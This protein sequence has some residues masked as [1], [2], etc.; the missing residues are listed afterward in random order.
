MEDKRKV[1]KSLCLTWSGSS[2]WSSKE[3]AEPWM[4]KNIHSDHLGRD[5]WIHAAVKLY[6]EAKRFCTELTNKFISTPQ[7]QRVDNQRVGTTWSD[8]RRGLREA[9][10]TLVP[11]TCSLPPACDGLLMEVLAQVLDHLL[12]APL[13]WYIQLIFCFPYFSVLFVKYW[14]EIHLY[15]ATNCTR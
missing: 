11:L 4:L 2:M 1:Y 8:T 15:I 14:T 3:R 10:E 12:L 5:G 9:R 7:G 6:I 13:L